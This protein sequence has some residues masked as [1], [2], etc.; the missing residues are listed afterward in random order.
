VVCLL[1]LGS[2]DP[3]PT[4]AQSADLVPLPA[5]AL[6]FTLVDLMP[7]SPVIVVSDEQIHALEVWTRDFPAWQ[8]AVERWRKEPLPVSWDK[9]NERNPKPAP[10]AWLDDICLFLAD[11]E[12]FANACPLLAEWRDDPLASKSRRTAAAALQ[13]REAPK[14]DVWWRNLHMDVLWSTTQSNVSAFA[15]FG[16]H[17]TVTVE[18]RAQV[19]VAPGILLVSVPGLYGARELVPATDWGVS[20]RLFD[21]GGRS[22]HFNLVHA[23]M[24]GG[25]NRLTNNNLTLAGFS[26]TRRARQH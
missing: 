17:L 13:Q 24:L 1:A 19:F 26:V 16:T 22:V 14:N 18:G 15:L 25:A 4:Y 7:D 3:S 8:K 9:F 20:Y 11:D 6:P 23:W 5:T 21:I 12:Q 10:P 2:L